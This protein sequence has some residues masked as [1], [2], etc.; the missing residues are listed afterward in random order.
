MDTLWQ[1]LRYAFRTHL[2]S[3]G[4]V[5]IAV[6]S[7][8]VGI[9]ANVTLFSFLNSIY[10]N[11]L[12]YE[13][14]TRLVHISSTH[15]ERGDRSTNVSFPDLADW[16]AGTS[17]FDDIA[18]HQVR[19]L[20]LTRPGEPERVTGGFVSDNFFSTLKAAPAYGRSFAAQDG[21]AV[22]EPVVILSYGF[23]QRRFGGDTAVLGDPITLDGEPHTI[24][25]ITAPDF[26]FLRTNPDLFVPFRLGTSETYLDRGNRRLSTLARLSDRVTIERAQQELALFAERLADEHPE[27]NAGWGVLVEPLHDVVLPSHDI[28]VGMSIGFVVVGFMLL[29]ACSNVA[30]LLLARATARSHELAIRT[31]L[32]AGRGRKVR[33]LMTENALLALAGGILGVGLA[34]VGVKAFIAASPVD[35]SIFDFS[36]DV[37][38]L[39]FAVALSAAT[40]LIFGLV[41]AI[42]STSTD[43][44]KSLRTGLGIAK[45]G[46][47]FARTVIVFEVAL[48]FVLLTAVTVMIQGVLRLHNKDLGFAPDNV[49]T[50]RITPPE[51][52]YETDESVNRFYAEVL[53]RIESL[54]QV[55]AAGTTNNLTLTGA[56]YGGPFT[57]LGRREP[58]DTR[59]PRVSLRSLSPGYFEALSVER[60]SGRGFSDTDRPG[61]PLVAIVNETF[62]REWFPDHSPLGERIA[63]L[64]D[65]PREIIG[66]IQDF[67][68]VRIDRPIG[69]VVYLPSAQAPVQGRSVAVRVRGDAASTAPAVERAVRAVDPD[70][71]VYSVR[72]MSDYVTRAAWVFKLMTSGFAVFS[73]IALAMGAAGIFGVTS[74]GVSRRRSEIGLRMALGAKRSDVL[75]MILKEG[76]NRT[77]IGFLIGLPLSFALTSGL[78]SVLYGVDRVDAVV[79]LIVTTL[80][81]AVTLLACYTPARKAS[82]V[83]PIVALRYE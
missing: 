57:I 24:I 36:I 32:G 23:W 51:A 45:G 75:T 52:K 69:P 47:Y 76:S 21:R 43:V 74:L 15:R 2:K 6:L 46:R 3:P 13:D 19:N 17:L 61:A 9:G 54:P 82:K 39:L 34:H 37:I 42:R 10:L 79:W 12:P 27:T 29:I 81:M 66:V 38:V 80:M 71:P 63:L 8:A 4:F 83:E 20:N 30:N 65:R 77:L 41:P 56:D 60:L 68:E 28:R 53:E 58:N 44:V 14:S 70:Q 11:P 55:I 25:G 48:A 18:A 16:K 64:D 72:P 33:Q 40:T 26:V 62:A 49:L 78:A 22:S 73:A 35:A 59:L 50:L 1:D 31:A 5:G 67:Y 7:L